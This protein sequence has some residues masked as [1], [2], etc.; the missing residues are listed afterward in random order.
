MLGTRGIVAMHSGSLLV[1]DGAAVLKLGNGNGG[2]ETAGTGTPPAATTPGTSV[3]GAS[4][5]TNPNA[6]QRSFMINLDKDGPQ[7]VTM[8]PT[9]ATGIDIAAAIQAAVR[10]LSAINP[11]HQ[12]AYAGFTCTFTT[13]YNL[14]SG[15]TGTGSS[16]AVTNGGSP[17]SLATP[18]SFMITA[19]GDGPHLVTV[20]PQTGGGTLVAGDIQTQVRAISPNRS[21]NK[22]A[23][24]SFAVSYDASNAPSAPTLL[25]TSGTAG[26][27]SSV[28][29][30][31]APAQNAA[32]TLKLGL[33]NGGTEVTGAAVL[34]PADSAQPNT[35]YHLGVASVGGNVV[36]VVAGGDGGLPV[37]VE[38]K[39][40]LFA[41]DIIRDVNIVCIP[42]ISSPDVVSTGTN[43]CAQ[44]TDCFFI[45]DPHS[46]DDTVDEARAFVNSL[47]V[48]SSY[49][50]V[51]Y[52][53]LQV[54]DPTGVSTAPIVVPPS[55]FVAGMY[56]HIDS[57]RGVWKAPAGTEANL[58]GAVGLIA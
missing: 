35:E 8:S 44:R 32:G 52:P 54:A 58:A 34:R 50:A 28:V 25:L 5:S 1:G 57:T 11:A 10:G 16:V 23:F 29:V 13:T 31:N 14:K 9:A 39:N 17:V 4:P 51:Y 24:S 41:L 7:A 48:K 19:N 33:S 22:S 18:L 47:T 56:A 3:S 40:G 49:G 2:T 55:G 53:W 30:T 15:T 38:H 27:S 6:D 36:S 20:G 45:G 42:G 12:A 26:T 37:D 46:T 21:A 43:Y